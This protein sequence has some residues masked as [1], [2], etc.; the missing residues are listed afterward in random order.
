MGRTY[1]SFYLLKSCLR[2]YSPSFGIDK[3]FSPV[4]SQ[5]VSATNSSYKS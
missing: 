1:E 4:L 2:E 5:V 3:L